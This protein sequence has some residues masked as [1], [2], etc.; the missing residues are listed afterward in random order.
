MTSFQIFW[1]ILTLFPKTRYFILN[2]SLMKSGV[3]Q[4]NPEKSSRPLPSAI[5]FSLHKGW[6]NL[7]PSWRSQGWCNHHTRL[8]PHC[9][10]CSTP[11]CWHHSTLQHSTLQHSTLQYSTLQHSTLQHSTLTLLHTTTL[12][13]YTTPHYNTPHLH[14]CWQHSTL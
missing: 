5:V 8:T 1:N 4:F 11:H 6:E 10:H 12:Q 14:H 13:T 2:D 7:A 3:D 9:S